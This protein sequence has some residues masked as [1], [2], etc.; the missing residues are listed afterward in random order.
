MTSTV[1]NYSNNINV[2]YPVAGVDNDTQGFRDNFTYIQNALTVAAGEIS[3]VQAGAVN[4]NTATNDF[5]WSIIYRA[6]QQANALVAPSVQQITAANTS[7]SFLQGSYQT[8]QI[9]T[10]TTLTITDWPTG[11]A[12]GKVEFEIYNASSSTTA[13]LTILTTPSYTL[14]VDQ[15]STTT[16]TLSTLSY[17]NPTIVEMWNNNVSPNGPSVF[18][19]K[20]GGTYQ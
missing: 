6:T 7:V 14:K 13:T 20:V 5:Y 12:V 16:I 8:I 11:N 15:Y 9:T 18:L 17:S 3:A 10:S 2:L 19:R 4:V 1:T